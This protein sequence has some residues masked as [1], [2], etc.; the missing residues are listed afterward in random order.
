MIRD[1]LLSLGAARRGQSGA[2]RT[3]EA[4]KIDIPGGVASQLE[5]LGG[6]VL[7]DG[8]EVDGRAGTDSLG[9]VALAQHAVDTTDRELKSGL[10]RARLS[11]GIARGLS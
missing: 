4:R 1:F 11:L 5:D 6:E 10:G 9:V 7:E 8:G 2:H 3:V